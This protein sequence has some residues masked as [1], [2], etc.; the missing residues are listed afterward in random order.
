MCVV[1][2]G[3]GGACMHVNVV[4]YVCMLVSTKCTCVLYV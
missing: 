1:V 4:M 3:G 2:G